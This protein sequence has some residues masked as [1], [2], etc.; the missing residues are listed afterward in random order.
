VETQRAPD[1]QA[2]K[3]ATRVRRGHGGSSTRTSTSRSRGV[4]FESDTDSEGKRTR[5]GEAQ[6]PPVSTAPPAPLLPP[7]GQASRGGQQPPR[8]GQQPTRGAST[9]G[10]TSRLTGQGLQVP[11]LE[12]ARTFVL[13]MVV[14]PTLVLSPLIT[15]EIAA[16]VGV[17]QRPRTQHNRGVSAG[18]TI[19]ASTRPTSI[20]PSSIPGP[21]SEEAGRPRHASADQAER[22]RSTR[23]VR[24]FDFGQAIDNAYVPRACKHY[25]SL[26]KN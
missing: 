25:L 1:T 10:T 4:L 24:E 19:V 11:E 6:T 26:G 23:P 13:A 5:S 9:G 3:R 16:Q 12:P 20:P 8:G 22:R 18:A 15:K 2:P 7:P 21:S 14:D 17:A